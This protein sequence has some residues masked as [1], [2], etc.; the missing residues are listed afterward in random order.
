MQETSGGRLCDACFITYPFCEAESAAI[1][2]CLPFFPMQLVPVN[3]IVLDSEPVPDDRSQP[4]TGSNAPL[5]SSGA[6]PECLICE[7]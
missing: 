6:G 1:H 3:I 5:T 2:P 7:E 4:A